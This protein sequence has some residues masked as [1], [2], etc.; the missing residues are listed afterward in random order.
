MREIRITALAFSALTTTV[1]A[2]PI[3]AATGWVGSGWDYT[4]PDDATFSIQSGGGNYEVA[5]HIM[6]HGS[7]LTWS[8]NLTG[9]VNGQPTMHFAADYCSNIDVLWAPYVSASDAQ[10]QGACAGNPTACESETVFTTH[11]LYGT[12]GYYW[13]YQGNNTWTQYSDNGHCQ[14]GSV[15]YAGGAYIYQY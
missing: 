5:Y 13:R 14:N 15:L 3:A 7:D 12:Y 11:P 10:G 8:E 2:T 1:L 6:G 4:I 9:T